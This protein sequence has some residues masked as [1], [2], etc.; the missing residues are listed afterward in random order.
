ME[1]IK[2]ADGNLQT[3]SKIP[4]NLREK[5]KEVFEIE[6]EWL[7]KAAAYRGKWI[8][9]S[10]SLNLFIKGNSGKK[11]SDLYQS[12]WAR[13]LKTTY[14]LRTLAATAVEK[15]T[16]DLAKQTNMSTVVRQTEEK[17]KP[18][19]KEPVFEPKPAPVGQPLLAVANQGISP[20]AI[21]STNLILCKID[22]P[23]CEAC[24]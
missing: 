20:V 18:P 15:S 14:Y 16:L 5:Y 10:Q 17:L 11:I 23:D 21:S 22:D 13:G 24:Q 4:V 12:A 3:L 9:Q 2:A 6:P 7:I 19:K 1:E 8:D